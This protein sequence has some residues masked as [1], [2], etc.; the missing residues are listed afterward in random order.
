[1]ANVDGRT[2]P[3]I[4]DICAVSEIINV[5][6]PCSKN[7]HLL[8][9]GRW[10]SGGFKIWQGIS[11][12]L[13]QVSSDY[14]TLA[15]LVLKIQARPMDEVMILGSDYLVVRRQPAHSCLVHVPHKAA[16]RLAEGPV[17]SMVLASPIS[18]SYS[19]QPPIVWFSSWSQRH[20]GWPTVCQAQCLSCRL[21]PSLPP[22]E[23]CL[24]VH[25]V[26]KLSVLVLIEG[27][28]II[29]MCLLR[30][31]HSVALQ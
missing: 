11:T 22:S 26:Q 13:A 24:A 30:A 28:L 15:L 3:W 18:Q 20:A 31:C 25:C 19:E 29:E 14:F 21:S 1:M 7:G 4:Q 2:E 17:S 5:K 9:Q 27:N 16:S 6:P 12:I 23:S 10:N 8:F